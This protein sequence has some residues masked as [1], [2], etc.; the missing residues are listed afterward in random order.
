MKFVDLHLIEGLEIEGYKTS[1]N[2]P[3]LPFLLG[4]MADKDPYK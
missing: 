4:Q 1:A 2:I 3:S